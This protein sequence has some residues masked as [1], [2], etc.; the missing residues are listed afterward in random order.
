MFTVV[1][2]LLVLAAGAA[3]LLAIPK[4]GYGTRPIPRSHLDPFEPRNYL[5]S[6]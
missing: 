5:T 1:I 6:N 2:V 4:D 3:S